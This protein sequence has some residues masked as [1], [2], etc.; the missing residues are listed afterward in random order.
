[1]PEAEV[2]LFHGIS[3][4]TAQHEIYE[5][6]HYMQLCVFGKSVFLRV[7]KNTNRQSIRSASLSLSISFT[8]PHP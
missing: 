4:Q 3:G 1:M 5:Y 2:I 8:L 7:K 6:Y